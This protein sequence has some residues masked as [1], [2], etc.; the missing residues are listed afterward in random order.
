MDTDFSGTGGAPDAVSYLYQALQ[1]L[2]CYQTQPRL[3]HYRA[4]DLKT[5]KGAMLIL[6]NW[7]EASSIE[8]VFDDLNGRLPD[9]VKTALD[10]LEPVAD[11]SEKVRRDN[12]K[13]MLDVLCS[14]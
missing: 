8:H 13:Q 5:N 12:Y 1:L 14:S 3:H 10:R 2:E 4:C 7:S 11:A 9:D 6:C